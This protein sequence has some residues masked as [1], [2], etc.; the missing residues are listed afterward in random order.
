MKSGKGTYTTQKALA[1]ELNVSRTTVAQVL[2][3][4]AHRYSEET[5]RRVWEAA[6]RLNY[7]PHRSAQAM[8]RGRS[9]LIGVIHFG[10]SYE[11]SRQMRY[12]L[13]QEVGVCGYEVLPVEFSLMPGRE[14]RVVEQLL[15][16]RVE[17]VIIANSIE[18]FGEEDIHI[19]KSAGL[20]V[21]ALSGRKDWGLPA[22]YEDIPGVMRR[23]VCHLNDLGHRDLLLLTN[24]Y[25]ARQT[26][27]RIQ[28]F[29]EGL[30]QCGGKI[31]AAADDGQ[32]TGRIERVHAD[33]GFFD[34]AEP[35]YH[36]MKSL[37]AHG[38]PLPDAVLC[39]NDHWA[40]GVYAAAH[41]A[42]LRVPDDLALT[43]YDNES[44]GAY[45]PFEFTTTVTP[46]AQ[47]V[48]RAVQMLMDLI[49]HRPLVED[50]CVFPCELVIRRSCGTTL[51]IS[52]PSFYESHSSC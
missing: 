36:F 25:E 15:E 29:E 28:G 2:G 34:T 41:E 51:S 6:R 3:G 30:A 8:R 32:L 17:G 16:A 33:R 14:H 52:P 50:Q 21:V 39:H 47:E 9:N 20:P 45:P 37:I 19:L 49:H 46:I 44:F 1:R 43:G 48:E 27:C 26:L 38:G 18:S 13:V 35:A 31:G 23:M 10:G 22:V 24:L 4:M 40:R 12:G 5:Q 11:V 7:R 42:G